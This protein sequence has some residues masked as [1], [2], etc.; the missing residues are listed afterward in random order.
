M[1]LKWNPFH[2][3]LLSWKYK[4]STLCFLKSA[5]NTDL[6]LCQEAFSFS[7]KS[8]LPQ[9]LCPCWSG[10]TSAVVLLCHIHLSTDITIILQWALS[11]VLLILCGLN[12]SCFIYGCIRIMIFL[13]FLW[14]MLKL[15][16]TKES[17]QAEMSRVNHPVFLFLKA[18]PQQDKFNSQEIC[19]W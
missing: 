3:I 8:K 12:S 4:V 9:C 10:H 11:E 14:S 15:R 2:H 13:S 16:L 1:Y 7:S 5:L 6:L 17:M 19:F 18:F